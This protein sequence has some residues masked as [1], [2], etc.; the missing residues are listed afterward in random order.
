MSKPE[1]VSQ[2]AWDAADA[3][4]VGTMAFGSPLLT[5]SLARAIM[6]AEKRGEERES[7]AI[8]T[9]A[10]EYVWDDHA[11]AQATPI[12]LACHHQSLEI[13]AAIRNRTAS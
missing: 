1:D 6:A 8:L 4:T 10:S 7:E 11:L 9:L 3:V 2:E 12:G 5:A 13:I